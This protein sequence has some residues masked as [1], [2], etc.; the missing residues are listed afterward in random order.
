MWKMVPPCSVISLRILCFSL[1]LQL[2]GN[3]IA[4]F[5]F[6]K[7][8]ETAFSFSVSAANVNRYIM[9]KLEYLQVYY[10]DILLTKLF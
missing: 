2:V 9:L 5:L 7:R 3:S 4:K 8:L 1:Y 10:K 6:R